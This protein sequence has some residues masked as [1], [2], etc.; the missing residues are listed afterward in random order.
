MSPPTDVIL[1]LY[2]PSFTLLTEEARSQ[3]LNREVRNQKR[4]FTV[5]NFKIHCLKFN[6]AITFYSIQKYVQSSKIF[7]LISE[8]SN[9]LCFGLRWIEVRSNQVLNN[10]QSIIR[11]SEGLRLAD[12]RSL[13]CPN[14]LKWL[15]TR[16]A[17]YE[18]IMH[19]AW[20]KE[21]RYFGQSYDNPG[22]LD[23]S[24]LIMPLVFFMHA[25]RTSD[26]PRA[27]WLNERT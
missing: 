10:K 9:R 11:N 24:V 2:G 20:N 4:H 15:A 6:A 8:C 13:P 22:V 26:L 18:D 19:N 14:R 17:I 12:K 7:Y 25:V 16:D 1:D 5:R 23:S 21:G 27:T 3:Q